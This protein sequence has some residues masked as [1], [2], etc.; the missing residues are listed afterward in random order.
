[1]QHFLAE[2]RQDIVEEPAR[3]LV[4]KTTVRISDPR[5]APAAGGQESHLLFVRQC[6][7]GHLFQ[8]VRALHAAGGLAGRH[9]GRKKQADQDSD[10]SN[11]HQQLNQG[12]TATLTLPFS[13]CTSKGQGLG[14]NRFWTTLRQ[15]Y[16]PARR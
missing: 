16:R 12:E 14:K 13:S 4:A 5:A 15:L 10:D 7:E 3:L 8:V 9:H 11:R 2:E 1:M 6:A